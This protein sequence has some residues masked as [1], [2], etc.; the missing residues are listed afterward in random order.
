MSVQLIAENT[1]VSADFYSATEQEGEYVGQPIQATAN[2]GDFRLLTKGDI[3]DFSYSGTATGDGS[4]TTIVD[5]ILS[6]FGDD[7][8][9]GAT[10]TFTDSGASPVG[11]TSGS[12][13]ITDFAQATGTLTWAGALTS[14]ITGD[15]FTLTMPFDT[16][17][18]R[19]ELI[20]SGD[21]GDATFKWSH[22]GG[23]THL[24]R[25]DPDQAD[26]LAEQKIDDITAAGYRGIGI[27]QLTDGRWIVVY[28][29]DAGAVVSSRS[30]NQGISWDA[31][32][33]IGGTASVSN[34]CRLSSGRLIVKTKLATIY[35]SD[36][37]GDTW[38]EVSLGIGNI[39][40]ACYVEH[41]DGRLYMFYHLS[42]EKIYCRISNDQ[43]MTWSSAITVFTPSAND[44][45][46]VS[47]C[48]SSDGGIVCTFATDEDAIGEWEVKC[49]KSTDGGSTWGAAIDVLPYTAQDILYSSLC[50]DVDGTLY[51][52]AWEITGDEK[53]VYTTSNDHGATWAATADLVSQA[54]VDLQ[55]PQLA[56]LNGHIM[57]CTYE[58]E[59]NADGQI[60]R[61]G[62]WEA[63]SA[64]ACP[65]AR[66]AI[67]QHLIC[68]AHLVWHG[69]AGDA[70]DNWQ[71]EAKYDYGMIN[72]IQDSPS[73]PWRSEQDNISCQIILDKGTYEACQIDGVGFFGCNLRTLDFD[74][75]TAVTFDSTGS[76]GTPSVAETVSFDLAT[77]TVDD[78]TLNAIQDTSLMANY[79]DHELA[80]RYY[81]RMTSGTDD[82][83]TWE[84]RDN[85]G[86]W[87]FLETTA[88][89]NIAAGASPAD[90]FVIFQKHTAHTFTNATPYRFAQIDIAAQHT[91]EDYYQ[92]GT[93]VAGKTIT[94]SK[95]WDVAYGKTHEYDIEMARTP[96]YGLVPIRG[97]GR[98]RTFDLTW[99]GNE[100]TV[101]EVL[102]VLDHIN[103]KNI[104]L[105]PDSDTLSDCYLVKLVGS[106]NMKHW[107]SDKF[108]MSL[109]LEEVL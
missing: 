42:A 93:M 16:R 61:R 52:A 33:T 75:D 51:C 47:A 28:E 41:W 70:G 29:N 82:G 7:Y 19:V 17:D 43:G 88:A 84:I 90:T 65:C 22:D 95:A 27:T 87:I 38:T 1:L 91:A 63:Y 46:Y 49:V 98:R 100:T 54:G 67:P 20:T 78:A 50:R 60:S 71:F 4:T 18:F 109:T 106:V 68:D 13:T 85:T 66:E 23:T 11:N 55:S 94:L 81:L 77:G 56:L 79:K 53:I 5:S 108:D 103:G 76:P 59:T 35:Y 101:E 14:T 62:I 57:V 40:T 96:H 37:E 102:A 6:A 107:H 104:V 89:N 45:A 73:K 48:L 39:T 32:V 72:L 34:L 74:L 3:A 92:I 64:N 80:G 44:A 15:T 31:T 105:I 99:S 10:I 97:A 8:F 21:T 12:K 86:D 24:G 83:V 9:I 36:N 26:W 58:D 25:D 69:G 30:S 2:T